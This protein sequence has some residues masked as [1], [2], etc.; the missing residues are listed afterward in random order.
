MSEAAVQKLV[1]VT[2]GISLLFLIW[3]LSLG[4]EEF[5]ET[6]N[7]SHETIL[8]GVLLLLYNLFCHVQ[9]CIEKRGF[10]PQLP[11]MELIAT[12]LGLWL[13]FAN[14]FFFWIMGLPILLLLISG[15]A[16]LAGKKS[17][18]GQFIKGV[19]KAM[20]LFILLVFCGVELSESFGTM[21]L[22]KIHEAILVSK[23]LPIHLT[24]IFLLGL[25][26]LVPLFFIPPFSFFL[27]DYEKS[28][29]W[30]LFAYFRMLAPLLGCLLLF[31]WMSIFLGNGV[32]QSFPAHE[33]WI[34]KIS[35]ILFFGT[36]G[37]IIWLGL[38]IAMFR[39]VSHLIYFVCFTP[40]AF[41]LMSLGLHDTKVTVWGYMTL[42]L[43][44]LGVPL[45]AHCLESL[46]C[47]CSGTISDLRSKIARGDLRAKLTFF[48]V[49]LFMSPP[50]NMMG[51]DLITYITRQNTLNLGYDTQTIKIIFLLAAI[52]PFVG[53]SLMVM[54]SMNGGTEHHQ[55]LSSTN[56]AEK[57]WNYVL[58]GLFIILG[59]SPTPLYNY[60]IEALIH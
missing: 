35:L 14:H 49:L 15:A 45:L 37:L 46:S 3:K 51:F 1:L 13:V 32:S 48:I 52:Y 11:A 53:N 57:I 19:M 58:L 8:C 6:L 41:F 36:V 54:R 4:V 39:K 23:T 16:L 34:Q 24:L 60:V 30:G 18:Q 44:V 47:K 31:R 21:E 38:M 7:F 2:L 59:I 28:E 5:T 10:Q 25:I 33:A 27:S 22:N 9:L 43:Y 40:L 29:S 42:F 55:N 20:I 50:M 12:L 17:V 56:E 26:C